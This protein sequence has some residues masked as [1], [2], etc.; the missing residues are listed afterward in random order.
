MEKL[1]AFFSH[2]ILQCIRCSQAVAWIPGRN[3]T[4][5]AIFVFLFHW[6]DGIRTVEKSVA[7]SAM[8]ALL[9][10]LFTKETAVFAARWR[11][12]VIF[13]KKENGLIVRASCFMLPGLL[14]D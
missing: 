4:L 11:L 5:L 6:C 10:A 13:L 7:H 2:L 12:L 9:A 14:P 3:D 1:S 8:S